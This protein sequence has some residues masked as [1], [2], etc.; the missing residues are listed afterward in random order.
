VQARGRNPGRANKTRVND[1][2]V[3]ST[4]RNCPS[5]YI[6]RVGLVSGDLVSGSATA[7]PSGQVM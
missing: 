3:S 6:R 7:V 1:S 4:T 5:L 2:L